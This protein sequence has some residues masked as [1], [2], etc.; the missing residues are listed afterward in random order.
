MTIITDEGVL[1][2]PQCGYQCTYHE[3]ITVFDRL[4]EDA[5]STFLTRVCSYGTVTR[6]VP[7]SEVDNPSN[8]RHGLAIEFSC[9]GCNGISEL[10]VAQHKGETQLEVR[11]IRLRS[12]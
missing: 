7:S 11:V 8:R 4:G 9:E 3:A 6:L 5:E 1:L 2:C 12:I 10:T